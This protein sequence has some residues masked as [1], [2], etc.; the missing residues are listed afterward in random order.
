MALSNQWKTIKDNWLI[1]AAVIGLLVFMNIGGLRNISYSAKSLAG[2]AAYAPS[3][4]ESRSDF[5]PTP[6]SGS[7][8][9]EVE[10][11]KIVK[12]ASMS[13]EVE[14]GGFAAGEQRLKDAVSSTGSYL[15]NDNVNKYGTGW[16][17]YRSG[18]YQIKVDTAKYD[19]LVSQLKAIGEVQSFNENARDVTGQYSNAEI[20]LDIEKSRLVRYQQ[21]YAEAKLVADKITLNDRIFDQE[22]T[23]KYLEDSI[24]QIDERI[25]YTTVSFTLNEK[26]SGYAN[27]AFVKLSALVQNFVDSVNS[28]LSFIVVVLP[29]AVAALIGYLIWRLVKRKG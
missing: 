8:A 28:L 3:Y 5:M 24:A 23:I 26:Q 20:N 19:T 6:Q 11:R 16:G 18:S 13:T 9:P 12:T 4:D 14:K 10:E 1:I 22:R 29:W 21:M 7:F 25:D 15:L 2:D 17:E 27:V